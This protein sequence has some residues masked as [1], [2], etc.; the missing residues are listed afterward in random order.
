MSL[1]RTPG[2]VLRVRPLTETSLIVRWLTARH[3]RL[4][5]VAKGARRP[6][7]PFRGQLDLFF[8]AELSFRRSR[9]SDLH[10]LGEVRVLH[11]HPELRSQLD[12][13]RAA[14]CAVHWTERV[15][16]PEAPVPELYAL[17]GEFLDPAPGPAPPRLLAFEWR[18]LGLLGLQ[19]DPARCGLSPAAHELAR[20]LGQHPCAAPPEPPPS[21]A[22]F[23]ELAR[24]LGRCYLDAFGCSPPRGR[25][26]ALGLTP[27][28][29]SAAAAE[30][31]AE[32]G[33]PRRPEAG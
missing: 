30:E 25:E 13:L 6:R 27:A 20:H 17:W 1:E 23:R 16:E 10:T 21:P 14:A 2:L 4:A 26:A 22:A 3:G 9:R 12:R 8:E 7:S 19:P 18:L 5:T 24:F 32:S 29:R 15:T 28:A 31:G 11:P 33:L